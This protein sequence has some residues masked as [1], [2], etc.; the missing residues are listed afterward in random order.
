MKSKDTLL[1]EEAY[2]LVTINEGM[3]SSFVLSKLK[4]VLA[5]V[6]N[7]AKKEQSQEFDNLISVLQSRD[8]NAIKQLFNQYNVESEVKKIVGTYNESYVTEG[9]LGSTGKV[10]ENILIT[11]SDTILGKPGTGRFAITAIL[12][13]VLIFAIF[14]LTVSQGYYFPTLQKF[15][16]V[17]DSMNLW[18][19]DFWT[20]TGLQYLT[21]AMGIILSFLPG[22]VLSD[23]RDDRDR[24][25]RQRQA[26]LR[27]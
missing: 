21:K 1:L 17:A 5:N 4:K 18:S 11:I 25:D 8:I 12:M 26:D 10:I 19:M 22:A 23:R 2:S 16:A 13:V 7:I 14:A 27:A 3:I 24:E 9:I 6:V 15:G 20:T